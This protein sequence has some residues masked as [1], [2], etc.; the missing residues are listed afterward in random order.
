MAPS[1]LLNYG[2]LAAYVLNIVSTYIIGTTGK[3]GKT[4]S[5]GKGNVCLCVCVSMW[6]V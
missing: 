5:E 3:V 2:N 1:R 6:C 4:N